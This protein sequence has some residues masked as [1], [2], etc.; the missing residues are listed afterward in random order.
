MKLPRWSYF[1]MPSTVLLGLLF[2]G[3]SPASSLGAVAAGG[4][5][6][7]IGGPVGAGAGTAVAALTGKKN[8]VLPAATLLSFRLGRPITV[9]VRS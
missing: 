3:L 9:S 2:A 4:K 5:G 6:A 7:L 1:I 8:V